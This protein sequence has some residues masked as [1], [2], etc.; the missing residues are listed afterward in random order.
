M[1]SLELKF[2]IG[3]GFIVIILGIIKDTLSLNITE[4][5]VP[6]FSSCLN[7][8]FTKAFCS[9]TPTGVMGPGTCRCLTGEIG[10]REPGFGG[11]CV[12]DGT[13]EGAGMGSV[14]SSGDLGGE[15]S[16]NIKEVN[17]HFFY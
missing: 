12:C 1:K 16:T 15:Y 8:G 13:N 14:G 4:H 17:G 6:S 7:Q 11:A 10:R 9:Q 5:F 3:V 2:F